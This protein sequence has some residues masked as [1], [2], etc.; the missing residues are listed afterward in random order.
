MTSQPITMN[1]TMNSYNYATRY[2]KKIR[3][4]NGVSHDETG[5]FFKLWFPLKENTHDSKNIELRFVMVR[6][7]SGCFHTVRIKNIRNRK[8]KLK[9]KMVSIMFPQH[10][11]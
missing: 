2:T 11:T 1:E 8:R 4:G 5:F 10:A 6:V 9:Q 3:K 7:E